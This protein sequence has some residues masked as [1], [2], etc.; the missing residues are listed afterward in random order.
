MKAGRVELE[1]L[2]KAHA[3]PPLA[4]DVTWQLD[5]WQTAE[6]H[7]AQFRFLRDRERGLWAIAVVHGASNQAAALRVLCAALK[8][9]VGSNPG[10]V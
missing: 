8:E 9:M 5:V 1:E 3:V 6:A 2:L 4:G 10:G 7:S